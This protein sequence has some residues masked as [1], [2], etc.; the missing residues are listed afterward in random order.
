MSVT[1]RATSISA[2]L[3]RKAATVQKLPDPGERRA[4]SD[5]ADPVTRLDL[6]ALF[7]KQRDCFI[8][9]V[10]ILIQQSTESLKQ[11]VETLGQQMMSFNTRLTKTE[12]VVGEN[13]EKITAM[14]ATV[15]TLNSQAAL[16]DLAKKRAAFNPVK[17]SL[18]LK[19]VK[20]QLLH[21]AR[22]QVWL[23]NESF[24]FDS[25][26]KAQDFYNQCIASTD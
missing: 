11:S 19:G 14:E 6:E 25:P 9:D 4:D 8:A 17:N 12:V 13:F 18:Y 23:R 7:N 10:A 16:L 15:A 3:A 26:Q 2:K 20:F 24:H 21:P 5:P 22:L 1:T